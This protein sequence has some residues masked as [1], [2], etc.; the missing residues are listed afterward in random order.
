MWTCP[1]CNR[2]FGKTKQPHSC[3]KIPL[4][5]HFKNKEKTKE[6]FDYLV[7]QINAKV[8]PCRIISIP[9]CV[10]LFG[11]YD[12]LAALP[13]KNELEIRFCLNRKLQSRRLKNYVPIST[14]A[15]KNCFDIS[16]KEDIDNECI[17]WLRESYFLNS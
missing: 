3:Q 17:E 10:H 14:K 13:K 9:C 16:K 1:N 11:T 4:E 6:I 8:G 12:F 15:F 2:I 7:E 5:K